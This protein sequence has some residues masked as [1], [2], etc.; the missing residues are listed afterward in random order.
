M[1]KSK[2]IYQIEQEPPLTA[3]DFFEARR[4]TL[5][6][7]VSA[8]FTYVI[9]LVQFNQSETNEMTANMT[10]VEIV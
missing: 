2:L 7:I 4:S 9:I 8:I 1:Q 6:A 3:L 10:I 5:T